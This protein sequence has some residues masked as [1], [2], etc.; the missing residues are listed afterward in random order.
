MK[1]LLIL[2]L[3]VI[4]F[5]GF[6]QQKEL[7]EITNIN[8]DRKTQ[9]L[10]VTFNIEAEELNNLSEDE[11]RSTILSNKTVSWEQVNLDEPDGID[12]LEPVPSTFRNLSTSTGG[13]ETTPSMDVTVS[14]VLDISG[15]MLGDK[16]ENATNAIEQTILNSDLPK[17]CF[18][19]SY[20]H[21]EP[22]PSVPVNRGNIHEALSDATSQLT[23]TT[24]RYMDTDL[25]Y[26]I[27]AKTKE[28]TSEGSA[29]G[30]RQ[31][32]KILIVLTDGKDDHLDIPGYENRG[33]NPTKDWVF[34]NIRNEEVEIYTIGLGDDVD[35]EFLTRVSSINSGANGRYY[36][37]DGQGLQL[38]HIYEEISKKIK[39]KFNVSLKLVPGDVYAG[40]NRELT[41]KFLRE[42]RKPLIANYEFTA[43]NWSNKIVILDKAPHEEVT[44]SYLLPLLL[45]FG[46]VALFIFIAAFL[47]P[48][49][50]NRIFKSRYVTAYKAIP[51]VFV[52]C[53][54][55]AMEIQEGDEIVQKCEHT[56]HYDCW[57][58]NGNKCT[59]YPLRCK[60]GHYESVTFKD[61]F[62]QN[63][64]GAYLSWAS[65][66]AIAM[67][68]AWLL[69]EILLGTETG[70]TE[71]VRSMMTMF[72]DNDEEI[73]LQLTNYDE[74]SMRGLLQGMM[75]A[76]AFGLAEEMKHFHLS[77]SIMRI[78]F[79]TALGAAC[80]FALFFFSTP[81]ALSLGSP[82]L[83]GLLQ[84]FIFGVG[85]GASLSIGSGI[86]LR[87]GLIGGA[88][89]SFIA[90]WVALGISA[91]PFISKSPES[92][93]L[94]EF[95][96]IGGIMGGMISV[97]VSLLEN[98]YLEI[99]NGKHAGRKLPVSKWLKE[100][101]QVHIGRE[102]HNNVV[103]DWETA[104]G[105]THAEMSHVK[106]NET[107]SIRSLDDNFVTEVNGR[108]IPTGQ[109]YK[110]KNGD[111]ITIGGTHL[112][113][114]EKR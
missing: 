74:P 25:W 6:G 80:G 44:K 111:I 33:V 71:M 10:N 51:D 2:L 61:F 46:I 89:A 106:A 79:K 88:I 68:L 55:C 69:Y 29:L 21:N 1:Q 94:I 93:R 3:T 16:I 8:L 77:R 23:S 47:F 53:N 63:G 27:V 86:Q 5:V 56:I 34:S 75:L 96:F 49:V 109:D 76:G 72:Y 81:L 17:D 82:I 14:I 70:H 30:R 36:S 66:G 41:V 13:T 28:L 12:R 35:D 62:S 101:L 32:R 22:Y 38:R 65:F 113:Y 45:G 11:L 64:I 31:G 54:Y 104:I 40:E 58:H 99:E 26:T 73:A 105:G 57:K 84:Y 112:R 39:G 90:Y 107:T 78:L 114:E 52:T 98:F 97:V 85:I 83:T 60:D 18:F 95:L 4:S 67:I 87:N 9:L 20:F 91:I 42:Q 7:I 48:L 15:S 43:G 102:I 50:R 92:A 59:E 19:F 24:A 103:L 108:I 37:S 100:G 110:L